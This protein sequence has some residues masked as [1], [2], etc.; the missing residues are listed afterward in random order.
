MIVYWDV[1]FDNS[2]QRSSE[3]IIDDYEDIFS[4]PGLDKKYREDLLRYFFDE[5]VAIMR[6]QGDQ[7][8]N[9]NVLWKI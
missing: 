7:G 6:V 9:K 4:D 1:F 2:L 8:R 3:E 5:F